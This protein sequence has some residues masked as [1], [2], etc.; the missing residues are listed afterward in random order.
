MSEP[1]TTA[2][3]LEL[4]SADAVIAALRAE[5]DKLRVLLRDRMRFSDEEID[6]AL[7]GAIDG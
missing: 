4:K 3:E 7:K 6:A 1:F 2:Q 5:R